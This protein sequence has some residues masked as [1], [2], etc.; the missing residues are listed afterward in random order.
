[1]NNIKNFNMTIDLTSYPAIQNMT[2]STALETPQTA[3][4]AIFTPVNSF[5]AS[6]AVWGSWFYVILIIFTV[7]IVYVKSQ[8]LHRTSIVML[9][10]SLLAV[11]SSGVL[12]IPATALH[13]LYVFTGIAVAGTLYSFWVGD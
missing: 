12:Y 9:F 5:W 1:M 2:N 3:A 4:N 7:G 13:T 6:G 8:S 10:M 11:G